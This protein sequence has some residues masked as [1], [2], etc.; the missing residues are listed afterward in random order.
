MK[1]WIDPLGGQRREVCIK[2]NTIQAT[3]GLVQIGFHLNI[4]C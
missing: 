1:M 4:K 3:A 2:Q